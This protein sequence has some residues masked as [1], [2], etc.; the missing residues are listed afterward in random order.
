MI[1][2][3]SDERTGKLTEL[4]FINKS[5]QILKFKTIIKLLFILYE[6][7]LSSN[8][9][10]IFIG[11]FISIRNTTINM[12]FPYTSLYMYIVYISTSESYNYIFELV[13][14]LINLI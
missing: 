7:L 8:L 9:T 3:K 13:M 6:N 2:N 11:N 1:D 12:L 14:K 10:Y 4:K 5:P